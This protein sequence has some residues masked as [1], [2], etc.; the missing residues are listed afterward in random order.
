MFRDPIVEEVQAIRERLAARYDFDLHRIVEASMERQKHSSRPVVSF[1]NEP[2]EDRD[3]RTPPR[4]TGPFID[5][6]GNVCERW[7]DPIVDEVRAVRD[8]LAAECDYD[9]DKIFERSRQN[10]ARSNA[11]IVNFS[12]NASESTAAQA[13]IGSAAKGKE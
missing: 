10:Q 7:R 12:K 13:L 5:N 3:V 6:A 2:D 8:K 9:I 11:T 4:R 1:V